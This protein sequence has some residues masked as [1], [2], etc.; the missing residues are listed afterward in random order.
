VPQAERNS[1]EYQRFW[2]SLK[3]GEYQ[4]AEYKRIGKAGKEIW[5]QATYNPIVDPVDGRV[6]KVVKFAIDVTQE[7]EERNRRAQIQRAIGADVDEIHHALNSANDQVAKSMS[8]SSQAAE[9]VSAVAGAAE[10]LAA[11]IADINAR[12][13]EAARVSAEAVTQSLKTV[14]VT[15]NLTAAALRIGE[16]VELIGSVAEQTNLLALNATIEAARVGSAGKGFA[17]VAAEVKALSQ[18]TSQAT[19]EIAAQIKSVQ[20]ASHG[21]S[22]A[23]SSIS[24]TI[25]SVDAIAKLIARAVDTQAEVTRE[26]SANMQNASREVTGINRNMNEVAKMTGTAHAALGKV[27]LSSGTIAG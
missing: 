14:A 24:E 18:K 4:V 15:S 5:I 26:I 12:V 17:V 25:K 6:I 23:I 7:V 1:V 2:E 22:E 9:N 13:A 8:A 3:R 10:E 19:E 21:V 16:I 27:K 11:S 20:D